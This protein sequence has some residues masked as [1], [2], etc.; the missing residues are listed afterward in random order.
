MNFF[1]QE[2]KSALEAKE[3]AQWIAYAPFVFQASRAL[4]DFGILEYIESR[5]PEAVTIEEVE[6]KCNLSHY[7]AR[8]LMEIGR[9][10][11]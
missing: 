6:M 11:V 1:N 10:H 5:K 8:V 9:A 2:V 7:G 4:R 3:N